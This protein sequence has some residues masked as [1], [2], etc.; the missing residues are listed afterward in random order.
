MQRSVGS[1][2][3]CAA[4]GICSPTLTDW[5]R[6]R[7]AGTVGGLAPARR[8][9][10]TA[11]PAPMAAELSRLQ[12][13]PATVEAGLA[14]PERHADLAQRF[15]VVLERRIRSVGGAR[16][17]SPAPRLSCRR[18]GAPL[19]RVAAQCRM[20][21]PGTSGSSRAIAARTTSGSSKNSMT[22]GRST[23]IL[24]TSAAWTSPVSPKP[25]MPRKTVTP[26]NAMLIVKDVQQLLHEVLR[27]P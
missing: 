10:K 8:G 18:T 2:P 12:R 9:P 21:P 5:R 20:W 27:R 6:Q 19:C 4:E 17:E 22:S 3:S 16:S 25:A 13:E 14:T 24:S 11:E 23:M 1:A 15:D 7:D 26:L